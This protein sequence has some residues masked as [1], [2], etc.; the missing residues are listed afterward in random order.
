MLHIKYVQSCAEQRK[1]KKQ[2]KWDDRKKGSIVGDAALFPKDKLCTWWAP[3]TTHNIARRWRSGG[4]LTDLGGDELVGTHVLR[5]TG[6]PLLVWSKYLLT[7]SSLVFVLHTPTLGYKACW[8]RHNWSLGRKGG[9]KESETKI[10]EWKIR[11]L[12]TLHR[13][14]N[15][16][17][18][19]TKKIS[20]NYRY[21]KY[22]NN[23]WLL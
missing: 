2:K 9:N 15:N 1:Q 6:H 11:K 13:G 21:L 20:A 10:P 18:L 5:R 3:S 8:D 22:Y 4:L 7:G 16:S 17:I 12:T 19:A 23:Y 14:P